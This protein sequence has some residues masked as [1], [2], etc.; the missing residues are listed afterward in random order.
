MILDEGPL[1]AHDICDA[2]LPCW[3]GEQWSQKGGAVPAVLIFLIFTLFPIKF[4][5]FLTAAGTPAKYTLYAEFLGDP[6]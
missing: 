2:S 6:S 3:C 4:V 5:H 1:P